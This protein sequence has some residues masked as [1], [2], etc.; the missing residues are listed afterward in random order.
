M[1]GVSA[2]QIDRLWRVALDLIQDQ[3][4]AAGGMEKLSDECARVRT[5]ARWDEIGRLPFQEDAERIRWWLLEQLDLAQGATEVA[6]RFELARTEWKERFDSCDLRIDHA[7]GV[8]TSA[9]SAVLARLVVQADDV[10]DPIFAELLP[11][12][13]AALAL[14]RALDGVDERLVLGD[15]ESRSVA[16][17]CTPEPRI[18]LMLGEWTP[19]GWDRTQ[20]GLTFDD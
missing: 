5:R 3:Q 18:D 8:S 13:F 4:S 10:E 19:D 20:F 9:G 6:L 16:I 12:T 7:T 17:A 11:L 2:A 1:S 14:Q 15:A